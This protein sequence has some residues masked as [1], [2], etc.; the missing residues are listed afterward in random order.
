MKIKTVI[1]ADCRQG[2]AGMEYY[3]IKTDI[4]THY[5]LPN[6]TAF[7]NVLLDDYCFSNYIQSTSAWTAI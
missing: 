4:I 3:T 5:F 2:Q 6:S 1:H 7:H